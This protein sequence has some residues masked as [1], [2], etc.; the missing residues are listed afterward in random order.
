MV[1]LMTYLRNSLLPNFVINIE[2][3]GRKGIS[4]DCAV[5]EQKK[6]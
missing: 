3:F 5:S 1:D 4:S 6:S 2:E